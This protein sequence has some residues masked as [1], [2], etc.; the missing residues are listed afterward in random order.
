MLWMMVL[1]LLRLSKN[2][3]G[4]SFRIVVYTGDTTM[5]K[6]DI[7]HIVKVALSFAY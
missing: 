1:A 6:I 3:Y 2:K 5:S 7:L 4:K